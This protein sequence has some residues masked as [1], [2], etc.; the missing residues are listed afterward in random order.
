[1]I[2]IQ[3]LTLILKQNAE[4]DPDRGKNLADSVKIPRESTIRR[5][6]V[7]HP[8]GHRDQTAYVKRATRAFVPDPS[9][10]K[11]SRSAGYRGLSRPGTILGVIHHE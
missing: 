7:P 3:R 9:T 2:L 8:V 6:R 10:G 11:E 4:I 5:F 1:M